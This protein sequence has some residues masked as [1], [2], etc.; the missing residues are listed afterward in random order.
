MAGLMG[1]LLAG[2]VKA[3]IKGCIVASGGHTLTDNARNGNGSLGLMSV[4]KSKTKDLNEQFIVD[5]LLRFWHSM[6]HY[7]VYLHNLRACWRA[8][9]EDRDSPYREA[10][11]LAL[12]RTEM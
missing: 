2:G 6:S 9:S 10:Y 4:K 7:P 5:E 1:V 11:R 12:K 3:L 8:Q